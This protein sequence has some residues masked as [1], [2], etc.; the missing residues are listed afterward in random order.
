MRGCFGGNIYSILTTGA[1]LSTAASAAW[2]GRRATALLRL[3]A[4]LAA[5]PLIT[6]YVSRAPDLEQK[7][8]LA[9]LAKQVRTPRI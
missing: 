4:E 7:P 3:G 6:R 5:V 1:R 8:L 9:D 2:A